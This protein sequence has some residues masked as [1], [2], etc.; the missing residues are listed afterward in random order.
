MM[1]L[2][3]KHVQNG[4]YYLYQFSTDS[5]ANSVTSITVVPAAVVTVEV[6]FSRCDQKG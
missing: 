3:C 6:D 1:C 4:D 2:E 5:V